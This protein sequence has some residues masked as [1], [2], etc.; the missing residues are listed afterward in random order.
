[1]LEPADIIPLAERIVRTDRRMH[2]MPIPVPVDDDPEVA[3][4]LWLHAVRTEARRRGIALDAPAYLLE[5]VHDDTAW[6]IESVFNDAVAGRLEQ[7]QPAPRPR[8]SAPPPDP[9]QAQNPGEMVKAMR[10]LRRWAGTPQPTLRELA[11]RTAGL[12]RPVSRATLGRTLGVD[13]TWPSLKTLTGFVL[14]CGVTAREWRTWAAV[15][16]RL[17][18]GATQRETSATMLLGSTA[19]RVPTDQAWWRGILV[20]RASEHEADAAKADWSAYRA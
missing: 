12:S 20:E 17:S 5:S 16:Y 2:Y 15:W 7:P 1:M 9:S 13:A 8:R 6:Q 10:R 3:N 14:A 19:M 11:D 4:I 18:D